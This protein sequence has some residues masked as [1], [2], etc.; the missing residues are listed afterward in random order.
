MS[1]MSVGPCADEL[2]ILFECHPGT[3][4][5]S[6]VPPRPQSDGNADPGECDSYSGT[7]EGLWEHR[8]TENADPRSS[9]E[10]H[11]KTEDFQN[12]DHVT[13]CEGFLADS[14]ARLECADGPV[15]DK[16]DPRTFN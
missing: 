4:I 14:P 7:G 6:Q 10:K 3:P 15:Y 13:R 16:D 8:M 1:E 2:V 11:E 12:K 5:L 9:T